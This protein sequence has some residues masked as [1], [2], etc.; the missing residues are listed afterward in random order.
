[1]SISLDQLKKLLDDGDITQKGFMSLMN[2]VSTN[3]VTTPKTK[4]E[5]KEKKKN[6]KAKKETKQEAIKTAKKK[7]TKDKKDKKQA[8]VEK[9]KA[10]KKEKKEEK[11]GKK[12]VFHVSYVFDMEVTMRDVYGKMRTFDKEVVGS[13]TVESKKDIESMLEMHQGREEETYL[14]SGGEV[15]VVDSDYNVTE[16]SGKVDRMDEKMHM[17]TN[18]DQILEGRCVYDALLTLYKKKKKLPRLNDE[19]L[20]K[21]FHS[22]DEDEEI[23]IDERQYMKGVS[24]R[25][26]LEFCKRFRIK[27]YSFNYDRTLTCRWVPADDGIKENTKLDPLMF[28]VVNSHMELITDKAQRFSIGNTYKHQTN[29]YTP[30]KSGTEKERLSL[31]R[32][33]VVVINEGDKYDV[34]KL[35]E[36]KDTD[37]VFT[38]LDH[39]QKVFVEVL[40]AD[41][42]FGGKVDTKG[43]QYAKRNMVQFKHTGGNRYYANRDYHKVKAYCEKFEI[44]FKYQS[45]IAL[46]MQMAQ[47]HLPNMKKS[48]FNQHVNDVFESKHMSKVAFDDV[49]SLPKN[50]TKVKAFDINKAYMDFIAN[51]KNPF[52]VYSIFDRVAPYE[53]EESEFFDR[54]K[55]LRTGMYY[56]ESKNYF[57]LRGNSWVSREMVEECWNLGIEIDIKYQLLSS[58]ELPADYFKEFVF[59]LK[60]QC[61]ED[62]KFMVVSYIG[63]LNRKAKTVVSSAVTTSLDQASESYFANPDHVF[64]DNIGLDDY[65]VYNVRTEYTR[66]FADNSC[67]IYNQIIDRCSMA[68][69]KLRTLMGGTL[70][71]LKTDCVFVRAGKTPPCSEEVGGYHQEKIKRKKHFNRVR[72]S[73]ARTEQYTYVERQW[74]KVDEMDRKLTDAYMVRYDD[75]GKHNENKRI[76]AY[77]L[78]KKKKDRKPLHRVTMHMTYAVNKILNSGESYAVLAEAGCGKSGLVKQLVAEMKRRN[79]PT[80]KDPTKLRPMK[81]HLAA[82]THCAANIINGTTLHNLFNV[83]TEEEDNY[84]F[85]KKRMSSYLSTLDYIII[86]ELSMVTSKMYQLLTEVCKVTKTKVIMVGDFRQLPA[87]EKNAPDVK[88]SI[89]LRELADYNLLE[90]HINLRSDGRL[91][92]VTDD[93]QQGTEDVSQLGNEPQLVSVCWTNRKRIAVNKE[94]ME[95]L[96][97]ENDKLKQSERKPYVTIPKLKKDI[98][99]K[100]DKDK[101]KKIPKMEKDLDSS[102]EKNGRKLNQTQVITAFVGTPM[103]SR[104]TD[105]KVLG[106]HNNERFTVGDFTESHVTM[107]NESMVVNDE[108]ENVLEKKSVEVPIKECQRYFLTSYCTSIHKSQ[109]MT[110]DEPYAIYQYHMFDKH[111]KYTA[112]TRAKNFEDINIIKEKYVMYNDEETNFKDKI[113]GHCKEDKRKRRKCNV[114][115][116]WVKEQLKKQDRKCHFC[117]GVVKTVGYRSKDKSQFSID[118]LDNSIGHIK[119]NCVISC[120]ECQLRGMTRDINTTKLCTVSFDL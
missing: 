39:L 114:T 4:P 14:Y 101:S 91:R 105:K 60:E 67:P 50:W 5:K 27:M 8:K 26:V 88:N 109:G 74:N 1:M 78:G 75:L 118:R 47:K 86:D 119:S 52:P 120:Y 32:D 65:I 94:T 41:K 68:L 98:G 21:I 34:T 61:P 6:N 7:A 63:C 92:H 90:L 76:K 43:F 107:V 58:N 17:M 80:K 82:P 3:V 71:K 97:K 40:K 83:T 85:G 2:M 95:R 48:S 51:N 35:I 72:Y 103:I 77:N 96:V 25:Q 29:I 113:V 37:I 79:V 108:G 38:G 44:P 100:M 20:Y 12:K 31:A 10:E 81:Y 23:D 16:I 110:I 64:V 11:A 9:K 19:Q 102:K 54:K 89:M 104:V 56:V 84:T 73:R 45:L 42:D 33:K 36:M 28:T 22:I 99:N 70:L 59:Y 57:P 87:I 49:Y 112:L 13:F 66:T 93:V 116:S 53:D 15:S 18:G 62:Y 30:V 46:T 55:P 106:I 111:M 115:V 117:R 69:Y 24:T